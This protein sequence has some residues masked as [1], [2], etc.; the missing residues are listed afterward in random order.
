MRRSVH[1]MKGLAGV[2]KGKAATA[3]DVVSRAD[4]TGREPSPCGRGRSVGLWCNLIGQPRGGRSV[5]RECNLIGQLQRGRSYIRGASLTN[6]RAP[7][8]A[9]GWFPL[10]LASERA[11]V[12][13]TASRRTSRA[14]TRECTGLTAPMT[15]NSTS[16]TYR[17]LDGNQKSPGQTL[18]AALGHNRESWLV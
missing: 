7:S 18:V 12:S 17:A 2:D 13:P 14:A 9:F 16:D 5:G 11:S 1:L 8:S 4:Q 6:P 3:E 15:N 10:S